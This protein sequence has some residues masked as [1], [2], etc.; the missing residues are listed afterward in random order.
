MVVLLD[1]GEVQ[2]RLKLHSRSKAI[3]IMRRLPHVDLS[4]RG[5]KKRNLRVTEDA[6]DAFCCGRINLDEPNVRP[7]PTRPAWQP[8]KTREYVALRR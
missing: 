2:S 4:Q 1:A 3:E 8:S 6:L 7:L 5:A